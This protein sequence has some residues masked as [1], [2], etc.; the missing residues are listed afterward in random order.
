V[1][2]VVRI[3]M[4]MNIKTT[5]IAIAALITIAIMAVGCIGR[6]IQKSIDDYYFPRDRGNIHEPGKNQ[7]QNNANA[8]SGSYFRKSINFLKMI[9]ATFIWLFVCQQDRP[10]L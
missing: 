1:I 4:K 5:T 10:R 9:T 2:H 3:E 7:D 6:R 8:N